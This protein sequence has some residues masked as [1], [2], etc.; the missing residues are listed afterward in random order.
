MEYCLR[1]RRVSHWGNIE[2]L[3]QAVKDAH[4][5]QDGGIEDS[6]QSAY[7]KF[8]NSRDGLYDLFRA[9]SRALRQKFNISN[10]TS[11]DTTT[12]SSALLNTFGS[13]N[14]SQNQS[15]ANPE[16]EF[17]IDPIT[18]RKVFKIAPTE[19][20]RKPINIPVKAY[21]EYMAQLQPR[22]SRDAHSKAKSSTKADPTRVAVE[23]VETVDSYKPY[24]AYEP[25]GKQPDPVQKD[26]VQEGLKEFDAG[27]NYQPYFAYEPDGKLPDTAQKGLK[28]HETVETTETVETYKPYCAYEPDG[29]TPDPVQEGLKDYETVVSY[30]P[31][32]AY[33]PNGK[34]PDPVE[35]GLKEYETGVSYE[36]YFAYEPDGKIPCPVTEAQR[37][38]TILFIPAPYNK[39]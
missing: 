27:E 37:L 14:E 17:D 22:L 20:V 15:N 12:S 26:P 32:F 10:I 33:E 21:E 28:E 3:N 38:L 4:K 35:E 39:A 25:N 36:P 9:R 5:K 19:D 30:Q 24:F 8:L 11:Q 13:E 6:K 31:Y 2:Q 18:N 34:R 16:P 23:E 29:K 7:D 1:S